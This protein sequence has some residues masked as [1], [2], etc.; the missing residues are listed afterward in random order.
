MPFPFSEGQTDTLLLVGQTQYIPWHSIQG[1]SQVILNY[2]S[3][4]MLL[5]LDMFQLPKTLTLFHFTFCVCVMP[6]SA[7]T[8]F[9]VPHHMF[10]PYLPSSNIASSRNFSLFFLLLSIFCLALLF[11]CSYLHNCV[12]QILG[13]LRIVTQTFLIVSRLN[14]SI[15]GLFSACRNITPVFVSVIAQLSSLCVCVRFL[16]FYE[17]TSHW[18]RAD[19]NLVGP[20]LNYICKDCVSKQGHIH[21]YW[22][23][24]IEQVF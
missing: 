23:L 15:P 1:P 2:L 14:T 6:Q 5:Q 24:G 9:L 21:R 10:N 19:P 3:Y 4:V 20:Q 8:L 22:E 17:D 12:F 16:S 13:S 7:R 11:S 18:I